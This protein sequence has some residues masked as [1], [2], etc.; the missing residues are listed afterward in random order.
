MYV[1]FCLVGAALLTL[2]VGNG[3]LSLG[4]FGISVLLVIGVSL[5]VRHLNKHPAQHR[6]LIPVS[7]SVLIAVLIYSRFGRL[8]ILLFG[9]YV[10]RF[11]EWVG[12]SYLIFR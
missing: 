4:L 6:W 10:G 9:D 8:Q 1:A 2:A 5:V 11:G 12:L 3:W 7:I